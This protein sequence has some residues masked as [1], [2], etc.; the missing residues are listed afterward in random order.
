MQNFKS[1]LAINLHPLTATPDT[2]VKEA[3]ALMSQMQSSYIVVLA[4]LEPLSPL[5]GLFTE[6]DVVRLAAFGVDPSKVSLASVM[7]TGLITIAEREAQDPVAVVGRLQQYGIHYLPVVGEA[8]N[9]VGLITPQSIRDLIKPM[10]LLRLKRVSEVMSTRVIHAPKTASVL[11]LAQI[12]TKECLSC[13]VLV[14]SGE[15]SRVSSQ[16]AY[17]T[18]N[19]KLLAGTVTSPLQ[20]LLYPVGMVT[21]DDIVRCCNLGLDLARTR[22]AS[23][24]SNPLLTVRPTDSMWTA[25][26]IMQQYRTQR[27]VVLAD[28][29]ELVG[30]ITQ[31][32][33]FE[34]ITPIE[35]F[36]TL[37]ALQYLVEEQTSQLKQ[38]NKQLQI[39]IRKRRLVEEKLRSSESQMRT[40]FGVMTDLVLILHATKSKIESIE[41][42][43][44]NSSYLFEPGIDLV[45]EAV[46]Q[47][48]QD[49]TW[50]GKV[51]Q[52]LDTQQKLDFDYSLIFEERAVWFTASISPMT[53]DSAV[54]V[55]RDITARKPAN[56]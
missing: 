13:V 25:D 20:N 36:Q 45:S 23:V 26:K 16:L 7:T 49:Q 52:A 1:P 38:L 33:I 28:T 47:F 56:G 18:R 6:Q 8:G 29:G 17:L 12:M 14:D 54:W 55:A 41:I 21:E 24:M 44:T 48:F 37:E 9:L 11:E 10:E 22:A 27:L 35:N 40:I 31:T 42:L 34:A 50:F 15:F 32:G 53:D 43:P 19:L 46:E 5:V 4:S 39:E 2:L 30:I 3:V 51:R